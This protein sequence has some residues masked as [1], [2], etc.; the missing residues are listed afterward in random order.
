[1]RFLV[2]APALAVLA[3]SSARAQAPDVH[4]DFTGVWVMDTAKTPPGGMMPAAMTYTIEQRGDTIK[5]KRDTKSKRGDFISSM[6]Y[7]M[8]GQPWKNSTIQAGTQVDVSSILTWEGS[9]LVITSTL[10]AGGQVMH[11]VEKWSLDASGKD[12]LADRSVEA[13]GQQ[14]SMKLVFT[15]RP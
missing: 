14:F 5:I 6:V 8:D 3:I 11:Q 13:M 2:L 7:G 1:M 15:K 12:L 9:T 4:P 10:N